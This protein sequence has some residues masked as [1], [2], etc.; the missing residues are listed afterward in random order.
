MIASVGES[1]KF[2]FVG[3]GARYQQISRTVFAEDINNILK[4]FQCLQP[5][6][7]QEIRS[8][9]GRGAAHS[10]GR[11]AS[12]EGQM[13]HWFLEAATGVQIA[14]EATWREKNIDG[15]GTSL[16]QVGVAPQ[17]WRTPKC[18]RACEALRAVARRRIIFPEHMHRANQPVFMS[19]I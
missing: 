5:T 15:L 18:H 4:T 13:F 11:P 16:E 14:G 17:L 2:G 1:T 9:M 6:C 10:L 3:T 12:K 7:I 19:G 8:G